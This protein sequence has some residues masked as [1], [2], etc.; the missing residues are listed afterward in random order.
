[1]SFNPNSRVNNDPGSVDQ[2]APA[3]AIAPDHSVNLVWRDS[4]NAAKGS[5]IYFVKSVDR[6]STW[7]PNPQVP[8]N[9]DS[10]NANQAEPTIAVNETNT[11]FV[12]WTDSRNGDANRDIFATR[13]TNGGSTFAVEV[14]VNDDLGAIQQIQPTIATRAGKVQVAWTDYRTGG[15]LPYAIYT[16]SSSDGLTWSANVKVN[17]DTGRN[18]ESM[19]SV[20]VD[21]SGDVVVAW[22]D[23][24]VTGQ[25]ILAA[26]LDVIAPTAA[27]GPAVSIDQGA[28]AA[29]NGS[30][31]TD[32]LGIAS[33]SWDYGD[34]S[35]GS[36]SMGTHVYPNAGTYTATLT[37]V[38]YSGNSATASAM[39][40]VHDT[41]APIALGGGDRS[42]DEG[43]SLFFDASASRDNVGVI[44]YAWNFGDGS[45]ASTATANH[46]YAHPGVYHATLTVT[47]AA[48]NTAISNFDVTVR[49]VSPKASDLLGMIEILA[50]VIAALA[51]AVI[52]L[53]W[54]ALARRKRDDKPAGM[55]PYEPPAQTPPPPRDSDPLDMTF[56]PTPP[57]R[58]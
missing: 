24:Q 9:H 27:A 7:T 50:G 45:S 25:G 40:T 53:G 13:S 8:V 55:A 48:G 58:P 18:I 26:T 4:R 15:S 34:G 23:Q 17:G 47:D 37:V 43:Q 56:P 36:G 14:R 12:S 52:L 54:M 22:L 41:T 31:S 16:A 21:G 46:V 32:N 3:I 44:G 39:V 10:G 51:I 35:T 33:Y 2:G 42:A 20:A 5:D 49:A 30:G 28:S 1:V 38:D 29:L 6:G 11:I 19:P 57:Q